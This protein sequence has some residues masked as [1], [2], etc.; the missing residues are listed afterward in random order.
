MGDR[1]TETMEFQSRQNAEAYA[2]DRFFCVKSCLTLDEDTISWISNHSDCFESQSRGNESVEEVWLCPHVLNGHNDDVWDKVGQ[3]IGNLQ[4]LMRLCIDNPRRNC[5]EDQDPPTPDWE[6]LARILSH[7]RQKISLTVIPIEVY[8]PAWRAEDSRLFAQAIHGHPTITCFNGCKDFPCESLDALYSALATLPFLESIKLHNRSHSPLTRQDDE[9]ALKNLESLAELLRV[10]SLRSVYF[11]DFYFTHALCEA[12][13]IALIGGTAITKVQFKACSVSTGE[14]A[15]VLANGFSKNTSVVSISVEGPLNRALCNALATALPSNST[16]LELSFLRCPFTVGNLYSLFLAKNGLG[17]NETLQRLE[18]EFITMLDDNAGSWCRAFSFLR[19]NKA[20]K[21][22]VVDVYTHSAVTKH[23]LNAFRI[24]IVA[25][26][27]ENASLE[28]LSIQYRSSIEMK[29][30]E[31]L[32]VVTSLQHNTAL[33]S[34]KFHRDFTIRFTDEEDK[35]MASLLKKNYALECLSGI[36]LENAMGDVGTIL[37]LNAAGRRYLIEDGSSVSKGVEVLSAIRS[38]IN[39]VFL[40]LLENPRLC[41]RN[42]L[43]SAS[44]S[45]DERGGSANAENHHGKREQNSGAQR[46]QIIS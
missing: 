24:D 19:S 40:H 1:T 29:A 4:A 28:S 5:R 10:P 34:L 38:N 22:L 12:T 31:Y 17:M 2:R 45:V 7:M 20:L 13:A 35:Q 32:V 11:D 46:A 23:Y 9:F 36:D 15:A 14:C 43:E 42:A 18:I 26:L 39:C 3:A 37:R 16:L 25:M 30:E 33:K 8:H 44:D 6:R 27:E 21:S 41:D